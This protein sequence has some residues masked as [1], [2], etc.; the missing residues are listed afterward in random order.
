MSLSRFS[1]LHP[2]QRSAFLKST[3]AILL[4]AFAVTPFSAQQ[5]YTFPMS[6]I[7][8]TASA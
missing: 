6:P 3:I 5:D 1:G 8:V 4:A 7:S 2:S